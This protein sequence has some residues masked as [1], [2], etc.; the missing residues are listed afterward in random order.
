[1]MTNNCAPIRIIQDLRVCYRK[2][3]CFYISKAQHMLWILKIIGQMRC[4]FLAPKT[5]A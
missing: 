1:M 3:S 2:I 5:Y 4:L